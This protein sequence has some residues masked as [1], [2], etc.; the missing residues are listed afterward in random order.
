VELSGCDCEGGFMRLILVWFWDLEEGEVFR[1]GGIMKYLDTM[2]DEIENGVYWI[3][4]L[5]K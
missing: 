5:G 4:G 1:D 2:G 3:S